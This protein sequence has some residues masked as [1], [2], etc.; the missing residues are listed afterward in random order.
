MQNNFQNLKIE[1]NSTLF[2][3]LVNKIGKNLED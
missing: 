1:N 3:T 2:D